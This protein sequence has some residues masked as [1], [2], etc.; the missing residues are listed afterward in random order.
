MKKIDKSEENIFEGITK[1]EEQFKLD[2]KAQDMKFDELKERTNQ[3]FK[4]LENFMVRVKA[5]SAEEV[6]KTAEL[7][8]IDS[9]RIQSMET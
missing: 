2:F 6:R 9:K 8:R 7:F 3:T 5:V 4:N 1:T